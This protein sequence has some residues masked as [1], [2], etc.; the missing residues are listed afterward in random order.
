[1]NSLRS[2]RQAV[3]ASTLA[4]L[5]ALAGTVLT[6]SAAVAPSPAQAKAGHA[7][8]KLKIVS[9]TT[10]LAGPGALVEVKCAGSASSYC[11]GTLELIVAGRGHKAPYS[12]ERG[13]K[14]FLTVPLGS[15]YQRFLKSSSARATTETMQELGRSVRI[16]RMLRIE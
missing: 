10:R 1:M 15:D 11:V 7:K 4:A 3:L 12:I 8:S 14:Q 16:Q 6:T 9:R 13:E 5:V 2:S